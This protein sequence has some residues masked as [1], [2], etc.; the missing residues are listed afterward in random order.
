MLPAVTDAPL[1]GT[2][3]VL[4]T[5]PVIVPVAGASWKFMPEV[6][7]VAFTSTGDL[8][9]VWNPVADALTV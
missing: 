9:A 2:P 5:L 8:E 6:V 3:A 1:I 7:L 4:V